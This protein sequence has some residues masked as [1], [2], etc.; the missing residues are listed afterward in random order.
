MDSAMD[1]AAAVD[2]GNVWAG[3]GYAEREGV[4]AKSA[5]VLRIART[6]RARALT[7]AEAAVIRGLDQPKVSKLL[8]GDF[9][10]FSV[11]RLP[12]ALAARGHDVQI[13][14][15]PPRRANR[16]GRL[17]VLVGD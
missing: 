7:Q 4:L 8:R 11:E 2:S 1:S 9:R 15:R 13:V 3:L 17:S 5:L 16:R 10:G 12:G 14:V 6:I